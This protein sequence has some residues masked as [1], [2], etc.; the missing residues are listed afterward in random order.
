MR[1]IISRLLFFC[2]LLSVNFVC[3]QNLNTNNWKINFK[4]GQQLY[5]AG[6]YAEAL[7][8]LNDAYSVSKTI[9]QKNEEEYGDTVSLLGDTH[10]ELKNRE[11]AI[12]FY[13]EKPI[14]TRI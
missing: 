8:S 5:E 13:S 11:L 3:S 2:I 10:K 1:K 9:F 12:F 14:N 7:K 4:K 6:K